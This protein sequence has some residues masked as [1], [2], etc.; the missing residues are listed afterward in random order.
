MKLSAMQFE[1][2]LYSK[3]IE[4]ACR[5]ILAVDDNQIINNLKTPFADSLFYLDKDAFPFLIIMM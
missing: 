1:E 4:N 2:K 3:S 5:L